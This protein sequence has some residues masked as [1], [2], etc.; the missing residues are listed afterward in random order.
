MW[1]CRRE[2][3]F[4]LVCTAAV[5]AA[6]L[7]VFSSLSH[8][9]FSIDCLRCCLLC[10]L[11]VCTVLVPL[12]FSTNEEMVMEAARCL[13]NL[14][15]DHDCRLIMATLRGL[16]LLPVLLHCLFDQIMFVFCF[17]FLSADETMVVLLD[18]SNLNVLFV[19]CGVLM[20]LAADH[21][22]S[23]RSIF[24]RSDA[25]TKFAFYFFPSSLVIASPLFSS[26]LLPL[27]FLRLIGL[28]EQLSALQSR[29]AFSVCEVVCKSLINLSLQNALGG[30]WL[31]PPLQIRLRAALKSLA[32]CVKEALDNQQSAADGE[33]EAAAEEADGLRDLFLFSY[34]M[35]RVFL[36]TIAGGKKARASAEDLDVEFCEELLRVSKHLRAQI[37][38]DPMRRGAGAASSSS[39][40]NNAAA[41][42][43]ESS[44][45]EPLTG[46]DAAASPSPPAAHRSPLQ[47]QQRKRKAAAAAAAVAADSSDEEEDQQE[48]NEGRGMMW[49]QDLM[50]GLSDEEEDDPMLRGDGGVELGLDSKTSSSSSSAAAAASSPSHPHVFAM[51]DSILRQQQEFDEK[52]MDAADLDMLGPES[53]S[54]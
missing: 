3:S 8:S 16:L 5:A 14:S 9:L 22:E 6:L 11:C 17:L 39:S 41:A 33:A 27:P 12:L 34:Y 44:L 29:T 43:A 51:A 26:L 37:P 35:I 13:G 32:D 46:P 38:S 28:L 2:N 36:G 21:D 54:A 10:C 53:S 18:H 15:R 49:G 47:Q 25:L 45:L 23:I 31:P 7:S 24:Y 50:A 20:N 4:S 48:G 52:E 40:R 42:A 19:V 30:N 1:C